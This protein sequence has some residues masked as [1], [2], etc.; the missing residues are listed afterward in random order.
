MRKMKDKENIDIINTYGCQIEK[1]ICWKNQT[2]DRGSRD[3]E[4]SGVVG[5]RVASHDGSTS[6]VGDVWNRMPTFLVISRDWLQ[7]DGIAIMFPRS[8]Q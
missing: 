2:Q 7:T 6:A 8:W 3:S 5:K 1:E 4:R